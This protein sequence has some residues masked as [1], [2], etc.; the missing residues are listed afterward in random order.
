MFNEFALVFKSVALMLIAQRLLDNSFPN[1]SHRSKF[2]YFLF[3][4]VGSISGV[5]FF[6]GWGYAAPPERKQ[7]FGVSWFKKKYF[8]SRF[9]YMAVNLGPKLYGIEKKLI[10]PCW[11]ICV[12][13]L[14]IDQNEM[15]VVALLHILNLPSARDGMP[16]T[17]CVICLAK[18]AEYFLPIL[19]YIKKLLCVAGE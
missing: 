3:Q 4:L 15:G 16:A 5:S 1:N 17:M 13:P 7:T 12:C 9:V 18:A 6:P 2:I 8:F 10:L 19:I 11:I 14:L